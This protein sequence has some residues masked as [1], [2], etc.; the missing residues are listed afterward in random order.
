MLLKS[1]IDGKI[2]EAKSADPYDNSI[3]LEY[4]TIDGSKSELSPLFTNGGRTAYDSIT[5]ML[6]YWEDYK[7]E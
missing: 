7:E 4:I 6:E 1:K 2:Y 5:Q 3:L